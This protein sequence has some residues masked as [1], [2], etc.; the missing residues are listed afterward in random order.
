M[1]T[2]NDLHINLCIQF[3]DLSEHFVSQFVSPHL[4]NFFLVSLMIIF[5]SSSAMKKSVLSPLDSSVGHSFDAIIEFL[6]SDTTPTLYF[7]YLSKDLRQE[8]RDIYS[9]NVMDQIQRKLDEDQ[10]PFR[11]L[12][13]GILL[14]APVYSIIDYIC[15]KMKPD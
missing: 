9:R 12:S 2:K 7:S 1:I 6:R 3:C 14:G 15:T 11:T 8:I 13:R 10:K 5:T 4:N